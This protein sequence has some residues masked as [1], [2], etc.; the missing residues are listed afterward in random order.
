[1][2]RLILKSNQTT[3]TIIHRLKKDTDIL[4][5]G[6]D[7]FSTISEKEKDIIVVL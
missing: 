6:I 2:I 3:T 4:V 5:F 1:L 7:I